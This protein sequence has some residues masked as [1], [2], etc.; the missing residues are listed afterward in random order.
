MGRGNIEYLKPDWMNLFGGG[1]PLTEGGE[2]IGRDHGT[3]AIGGRGTKSLF[4]FG[5]EEVLDRRADIDCVAIG[6]PK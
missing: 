2:Q 5:S 1:V 3:H 4:E 6:C